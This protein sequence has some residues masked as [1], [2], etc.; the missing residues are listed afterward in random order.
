[1]QTGRF[2]L[3][4]QGPTGRQ[5]F[6]CFILFVVITLIPA[7]AQAE[8]RLWT[9]ADG[10]NQ[11]RGELKGTNGKL[12]ILEKESDGKLHLVPLAMLSKTDQDFVRQKYPDIFAA[13]KNNTTPSNPL[14]NPPGN[15]SPSA[16]AMNGP[17]TAQQKNQPPGNR[18]SW[19]RVSQVLPRFQAMLLDG[20]PVI[21]INSQIVAPKGQL[22]VQ[23]SAEYVGALLCYLADQDAY[24]LLAQKLEEKGFE[25]AFNATQGAE[26]ERITECFWLFENLYELFYSKQ[27][28]RQYNDLRRSGVNDFDKGIQ[29][30]RFVRK[31][32]QDFQKLNYQDEEIPVALFMDASLEN[33]NEG[34]GE[35][36]LMIRGTLRRSSIGGRKNRIDAIFVNSPVMPKGIQKT[37]EEARV[38][39][40][41][42]EGKRLAFRE[43]LVLTRPRFEQNPN[44]STPDNIRLINA[45]IVSLSLVDAANPSQVLQ[46][47]DLQQPVEPAQ[48]Q[49]ASGKQGLAQKMQSLAR[50][51]QL[52]MFG[53][54]PAIRIDDTRYTSEGPLLSSDP[55]RFSRLLDRIA[56]GLDPNYVCPN[57]IAYHFPD[58]IGRFVSAGLDRQ[59]NITSAQWFGNNE[60]D[61][62]SNQQSF[63]QEY[64]EKL[65]AYAVSLPL[66]F[67]EIQK[68]QLGFQGRYDFERQ[69]AFIDHRLVNGQFPGLNGTTSYSREK[70]MDR[71]FSPCFVQQFLPL[72]AEQARPL[73]SQAKD[74]YN[75]AYVARVVTWNRLPLGRENEQK[76]PPVLVST[77]S[78]DLYRDPLLKQHIASLECKP[79]PAPFLSDAKGKVLPGP[80]QPLDLNQGALYFLKQEADGVQADSGELEKLFTD[81]SYQ[82]K[83]Y[84][85]AVSDA[86]TELTQAEES[87]SSIGTARNGYTAVK[88]EAKQRIILKWKAAR[89]KVDQLLKHPQSSFFPVDFGERSLDEKQLP[90]LREKWKQ[91]MITCID[92]TKR[93][94]IVNADI[95]LDPQL[96]D[97]QLTISHESLLNPY[98]WEPAK[99]LIDQGIPANRLLILNY[100]NPRIPYTH[101]PCLQLQQPL[102]QTFA[103]I[104]QDVRDLIKD[105]LNNTAR[106]EMLVSLGKPTLLPHPTA[107]RQP[108]LLFPTKLKGIRLYNDQTLI[109]EYRLPGAGKN[110]NTDASASVSQSRPAMSAPPKG[111]PA[112]SGKAEP[113]T[114]ATCLRLIARYLPEFT[115]Q[116][117]GTLMYNRFQ[118]EDNFRRVGE[119][120][121]FGLN[122]QR[123]IYFRSQNES[124]SVPQLKAESQAF[125]NWLNR[126]ESIPGNRYT[127]QFPTR[128]IPYSEDVQGYRRELLSTGSFGS[129]MAYTQ[130]LNSVNADINS[131]QR[132]MKFDAQNNQPASKTVN[133]GGGGGFNIGTPSNPQKTQTP[134]QKSENNDPSAKE[135]QY[136]QEIAELTRIQQYF[137]SAP[138]VL[139]LKHLS[140]RFGFTNLRG[141]LQAYGTNDL[142][143]ARLQ[144]IYEPIFPVLNLSH[145]IVL[146]KSLDFDPE[147]R[148]WP[149]EL[150]FQIKSASAQ[151]TPPPLFDK[152]KAGKYHAQLRPQEDHGKYAIFN[153]ELQG[154]W[155]VDQKTGQ[156]LH[157][158]KLIPINPK[159]SSAEK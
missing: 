4:N 30:A 151:D 85:R 82:T 72:S 54:Y 97:V 18:F 3:S 67:V 153:V 130:V 48:D 41:Q 139:Y 15:P 63:Q 21:S 104:P 117:A 60:F 44:L 39:A 92:S 158:L 65:K 96:G 90:E 56:L 7:F 33:Y 71:R 43:D 114:P 98:T 73:F 42:I 148:E 143:T 61:K 127:L 115:Q 11:V 144:K 149:I 152:A 75:P 93:N 94:F 125:V 8:H 12:V 102:D 86:L 22:H 40:R 47:W 32:H 129:G 108:G 25:G 155:L 35:F 78:C 49:P 58:T 146:P 137:E 2:V 45:K 87:Y 66:R 132:K 157:P 131:L 105:R 109:Y 110:A 140:Y 6:R 68:V 31:L 89:Q 145:E 14:G 113:L 88:D 64:A 69:G 159:K 126:P 79:V 134:K 111:V 38:F 101:I 24:E 59:G 147:K 83:S 100:R 119:K 37:L 107:N 1:M 122:P 95:R 135:K 28:N 50:Q 106:L 20:S 19:E 5:H 17:Q 9:S 120:S 29:V 136:R 84:A 16:P 124:P 128:F 23:H 80:D 133:F 154:A 138:P 55:G 13:D 156:R 52:V 74:G 77:E 121:E 103:Q 112:D 10:N 116:N 34:I 26:K 27:E 70:E 76:I 142:E 46:K 36:P 99:P 51:H 141:E 57:F 53:D 150:E 91:W 118:H 62:R 81:Y 123:G